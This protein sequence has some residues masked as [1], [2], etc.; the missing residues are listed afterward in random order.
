MEIN[1][2]QFKSYLFSAPSYVGIFFICLVML[3]LLQLY[4]NY[5]Y[6]HFNSRA[7]RKFNVFIVCARD[8]KLCRDFAIFWVILKAI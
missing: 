1:G 6:I 8:G 5:K 2:V 3:C 4:N 7:R